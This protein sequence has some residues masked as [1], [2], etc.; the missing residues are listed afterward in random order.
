MD[1]KPADAPLAFAFAAFAA[2]AAGAYFAYALQPVWWLA[3]LAPIPVFAYALRAGRA[4]AFAVAALAFLAGAASWWPFLHGRLHVPA[5]ALVAAFAVPSLLFGVAALVLRAFARR[6]FV[7]AA[8][9]AV[10]CLW[11]AV[12]FVAAS[13]SVDGTAGNLAYSQMDFLPAIQIAA[14]GGIHAIGFLV[15]LFAASVAVAFAPVAANARLRASATGVAV[16][17]L[18]LAAGGWRL[19]DTV[20]PTLKVAALAIDDPGAEL[21]PKAGSPAGQALVSRY[22]DGVGA[23]ANAGAKLVLIPENIATV[24]DAAAP[25]FETAFRDAAHANAVDVVVGAGRGATGPERNVAY[26]FRAGG[27][28]PE[29][30]TKTHLV[31]GFEKHF[32]PGD[33]TPL[34][35]DDPAARWAVSICK[36]LDFP[37]YQRKYGLA[38]AGLLV[39]P[40]WD[41]VDDAWMHNR[42]AVLRGV[43]NGYAMLRTARDGLLTVSDDRGRV[44]AS[45]ESASAPLAMLVA[46]APVAHRPT[47][48]ARIG[49]V[50]SYAAIAVFVLLCALLALDARKRAA[51]SI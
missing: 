31:P 16:V 8:P 7:A 35:V 3:W 46:T 45:V 38:R 29:R 39:V 32:A 14:F 41:F 2:T 5:F 1:S 34:V 42:M 37:Q 22:V 26:V 21:V 33:G 47:W 44:L 24:D 23:A 28:K 30:Y 36:D 9:F 25:A 40:A 27:D 48:Y 50:F 18:A 6:G 4:M 15:M 20:A 51:G 13:T 43:E 17:A 49:D 12:S 11:T 10:A 19:A